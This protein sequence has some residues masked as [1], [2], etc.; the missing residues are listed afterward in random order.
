MS[1]DEKK[2]A[3]AEYGDAIKELQYWQG[4]VEQLAGMDVYRSPGFTAAPGGGDGAS[5]VEMAVLELEAA[6][7]NER[8]AATR[9]REAH[10]RVMA[11][12]NTAPTGEQRV[13]LL[14]R[15]IEGM[16]WDEIA[17]VTGKS[18]TWCTN[19]HGTA[20]KFVQLPGGW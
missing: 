18:R 4:R 20:L 2:R 9:T 1:F 6:E 11:I 13:L 14:R 8:A 16:A 5:K 3:L 12:I 7:E 19:M 15:Y 17:R 10:G